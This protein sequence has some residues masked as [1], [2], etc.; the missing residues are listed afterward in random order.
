MT[1][2]DYAMDPQWRYVSSPVDAIEIV[3]STYWAYNFSN[4]QV[5]EQ[6]EH[7]IKMADFARYAL[8]DTYFKTTP[9]YDVD[10]PVMTFENSS[11]SDA[12]NLIGG[13]IS[14]GMFIIFSFLSIHS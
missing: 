5:D 13:S 6:I 1:D 11:I 12:I 3:Q 4:G 2:P 9:C 8:F 14:W 10:C 7:A